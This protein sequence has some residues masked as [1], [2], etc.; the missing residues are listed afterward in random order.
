MGLQHLKAIFPGDSVVENIMRS[1]D[2]ERSSLGRP[3]DWSQVLRYAVRFLLDSKTSIFIAWGKELRVLYNDAYIEILGDRHPNAIGTP[4]KNVWPEAWDQIQPLIDRVLNGEAVQ[5]EDEHFRL[6]RGGLQRDAYFT[7]SYTP[8]RELDGSILGFYCIVTET[9][10]QVGLRRKKKSE[11]ERIYGLF[12]RSPSFMAILEGPD[13]VYQLAN[14]AYQEFVGERQLIGQSIA[15]VFPELREQGFIDIFEKV[16]RTGEAFNGSRLPVEL[17]RTNTGTL[18]K[19]YVDFVLQPIYGDM[20]NMV[21]IFVEGYDVTDHVHAQERAVESERESLQ[22]SLLL[23]NE[24]SRLVALLEAAPVG[25]GFANMQ[26]QITIV[27]AENRRLWGEHPMSSEVDEYAE[28]KGWWADRSARHGQAIK[29]HEWGLSRALAGESNINDVVEIEPF[30]QPGQRRTILLRA[31]AIKS[32]YGEIIG[33]VVAKTDISD[34]VQSE[35]LLRESEAKFRTIADAMP[36]MVWSTQ[37]DGSH[38]YY[39]EQW[40][41]FTGVQ[42]G[43]TDGD[44]WNDMFHPEDQAR[45][46]DLWQHSLATGERYEIEYRLKHHTGQYRWVLGRAL[47][48]RN[49]EGKIIRWMGTCTDIHE[50]K[51]AQVTL[52]EQEEK[53]RALAENI[54]QLAWMGD[55][56][57]NVF[58]Y[59]NRWYHFT[60]ESF[61]VLEGWG[62]TRALRPDFIEDVTAGLRNSIRI[63]ETW[64]GTFPMQGHDGT[65]RWFLSRTVPIRD[66]NGNVTR[67]LATNTDITEQ[68]QAADA[69]FQMDKRKDEFLA[70]LAHEL[71]NPLAPITSAAN[72]LTTFSPDANRLKHISR[73][74][75]R[76]AA[77]MTSLIDDLLDVSRVTRGLITLDNNQI[78]LISVIVEAIEQARPLFDT[79]SHRLELDFSNDQMLILGDKKRLVQIVANI[80]NNAAKYTPNGGSIKV[81]ARV[82]SEKVVVAVADNGIGMS[83]DLVEHAFELFTQGQRTPDRAQGGLGIGLALVRSLVHLHGGEIRATSLGEGKGSTF[84]VEFPKYRSTS[85]EKPITPEPGAVPTTSGPSYRVLI[86]DDN[87]DAAETLG[88]LLEAVGHDVRIKHRA[89]A[90]LELVCQWVPD[91]LLLDIGLP[92]M[93]GKELA[94]RVRAIPAMTN[95]KIAAITGY[96]RPEEV[97]AALEAG[98]NAHFVKPVDPNKLRSWIEATAGKTVH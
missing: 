94:R 32:E 20:G 52:Q 82:L 23:Q 15:K 27:N 29:P 41:Q 72:L 31:T 70:M 16:Y 18:E 57:G 86:V 96:G 49:E 59:N 48:V 38:D 24:R 40:Y 62:W 39:N 37:P 1:Y 22:T 73:V 7:F 36:Q 6:N 79:K 53:F 84:T 91:V 28:W 92:D 42:H 69:L 85:T 90:A 43:S 64:E 88:M 11:S 65:Y 3:E 80:L 74:I 13:L 77:H 89:E 60:G 67:W 14:P 8:L 30:G 58:W 50:T 9:T 33:A 2:W 44:G 81:S 5:F 19:K 10:E 51:L 76:Q 83:D 12:E 68:R 93:D 66:S 78:D 4:I 21:G 46:W 63:G 47:P 35:L 17:D 34:R 55:V 61:A 95:V 26:G 56:D 98:F 75:A 87:E 71:R 25:I 45:A 97:D 54:P